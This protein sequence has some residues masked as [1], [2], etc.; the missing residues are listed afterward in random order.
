MDERTAQRISVKISNYQVGCKCAAMNNQYPVVPRIKEFFEPS[1][2][3]TQDATKEKNAKDKYK[4]PSEVVPK[5]FSCMPNSQL[6]HQNMYV[7]A[8]VCACVN[9]YQP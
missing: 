9:V 7:Y 2:R 8:C 6:N 4:I 3:T 1:A 5:F